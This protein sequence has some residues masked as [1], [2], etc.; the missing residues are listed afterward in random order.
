MSYRPH[1]RRYGEPSCP[2]VSGTAA[3]A[4]GGHRCVRLGSWSR[5]GKHLLCKQDGFERIIMREAQIRA[6]LVSR[7]HNRYGADPTTVIRQELGLCAGTR[8]VDLAVINGEL[9]GFEI[10]SDHDTLAR[11]SGQAEVYGRVLDRASIVT[12]DKY[13]DHAAEML[14]D[15]WGIVRAGQTSSTV[16]L[17]E[18]RAPACNS[19]QDPFA[20]A[21]LLWRDEALDE[22][23]VRGLHHGLAKKRRWI[24]W[25]RMAET[26]PLPELHQAVRDR[27]RARQAWPG[28]Q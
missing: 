27:L 19:D 24:V 8:R 15:W 10:K 18:V 14:P 26:M 9:S 2:H 4:T 11:L 21:Q 12:T 16:E 17:T 6:Q 25:Q 1:L 23:R 28:G 13:L 5:L 3:L 20:L 7:L 22:L